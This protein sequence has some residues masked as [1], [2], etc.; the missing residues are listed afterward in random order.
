MKNNHLLK[1]LNEVL[2][3]RNSKMSDEIIKE[4]K[5]DVKKVLEKVSV[6]EVTTARQEENLGEHM[7]RSDTLEKLYN[8][9]SEEVE[10]IK[11]SVNR[12]NGAWKVFIYVVVPLAAAVIATMHFFKQ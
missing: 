2:T 1:F 3:T 6:L 8:H 10:P 5:E 12:F 7:R 9:L 4:I 11:A